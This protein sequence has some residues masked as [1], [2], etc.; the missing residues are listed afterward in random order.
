MN[1][2]FVALSIIAILLC[3]L[4]VIEYYKK[5]SSR[6]LAALTSK[7][8]ETKE[9]LYIAQENYYTRK[10]TKAVFE[11]LLYE[12]KTQM[13]KLELKINELKN[14]KKTD[15]GER[16][17]LLISRLQEPKKAQLHKLEKLLVETQKLLE[18]ID[19]LNKK[20]LKREIDEKT[21]TELSKEKQKKIIAAEAKIRTITK[22]KKQKKTEQP[23]EKENKIK[24]AAIEEPE[25]P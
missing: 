14:N 10:I 23:Q 19:Y 25:A 21:F 15:I 24:P 11:N 13:T 22:A 1:E 8:E 16:L 5:K 17:E 6:Q 12:Y 18:E 20:L 4:I 3:F 2:L 7:L 9:E